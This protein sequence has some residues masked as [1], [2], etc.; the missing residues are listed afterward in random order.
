MP[1][2]SPVKWHLAHTTWFFETFVLEAAQ[3]GRPPFDP[4]FRVLFNS[5]YNSVGE[6]HFRP[7]RGLLTRPSLD[8][9][10]AYR[11]AVD[12]RMAEC[13]DGL[14]PSLAFLVEVGLNHEQQHQELVL[15]DLLHLFSRNPLEPAYTETARGPEAKPTVLRWH[16][17]PGGR[18]EVG[19]AGPGFAFD[20]EGPR[21]EVL[22]QPFALASRPVTAGEYRAFMED[23]GYERPEL[24]LSDGWATVQREG[25]RAPLYWRER[26]GAWRRLGLGGPCEVDPDEPVHH[27]SFYEAD[28]YASW[29]GARLPREHEW[30]AVA[31][32]LPVEGNFVESGVLRPVAAPEADGAPRQMYGDVWEWTASPY[33][34]Y[35]RYRP[36]AGALG[37][38]NGKFM[39]NQLVLRGGSCVTPRKTSWLHMNLP[40]YSPSA[41]AAGR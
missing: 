39:C 35:P 41:P 22:L 1:D 11:A 31:A 7:E 24:W 25:W 10:L 23:G 32:G 18:V 36:A 5:Y 29:A 26:E 21:H 28:A 40:L 2:A 12:A 6:Q 3:S 20:N 9:V 33:D 15:T 34:A 30:E 14:D 8:E 19:H 13:W 17:H 4:A 37:E 38:Y 27:V 16:V